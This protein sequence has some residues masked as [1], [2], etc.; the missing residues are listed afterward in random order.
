MNRVQVEITLGSLFILITSVFILVYGFNEEKRMEETALAQ[1]ARS[2]EVGAGLYEQQCSRCHGTQGLGIPGLCP[3]LNDRYFFDDRLTDVGWSGTLEDYIVATA[4]SGR[5]SSTRPQT[6]PGQGVPAMP[7]FSE[8]FG[9]P[10]RDD[11]IRAIADFVMNWE[12]TAVLVEAPPVPSGDTVGANITKELP[13][14]DPAAGEELAVTLGCTACHIA[15]PTGPA[16]AAGVEPGIGTRSASRF[17]QSDY[18]GS[19]KS[20]EEYL[21]ESIVISNAYIVPSF[22]DGIMPNNYA[23][24]LTDQ[25]VADLIAYLLTFE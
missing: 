23:N 17:T 11:Q 21:F 8:H 20:A 2:I 3:P 15:A 7:S 22:S 16:W 14:G 4:S 1:R 9:G 19:A 6:Y 18:S 10:M 5:L 13:Q 25:Q 12:E 24:Q